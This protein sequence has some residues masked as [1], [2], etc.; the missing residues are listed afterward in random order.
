M[1]KRGRD[2]KKKFCAL[3]NGMDHS[4][5]SHRFPIHGEI[6][7]EKVKESLKTNKLCAKCAQPTKLD[8]DC[9]NGTCDNIKSDCY[10]CSSPSQLN[11]LCDV[12]RS[13]MT[14]G[15]SGVGYDGKEPHPIQD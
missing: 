8:Q 11:F 15:T 9:A 10:Y 14:G 6:S 5:R 1:T 13:N 4:T 2:D 12:P 7:L 3:C